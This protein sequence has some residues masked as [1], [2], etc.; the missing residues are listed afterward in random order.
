[1]KRVARTDKHP[2]IVVIP[3]VVMVAVV[4]VQ[5]EVIVV[6]FNVEHVE[7]AVRVGYV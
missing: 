7:V 4:A 5:P 2:A 3:E 6:A 1:M